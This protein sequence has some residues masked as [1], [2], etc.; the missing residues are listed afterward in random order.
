MKF[1]KSY[2]NRQRKQ[3]AAAQRRETRERFFVIVYDKT[4]D[5]VAL[6]M[7]E[8]KA[9]YSFQAAQEYAEIY[10]DSEKLGAYVQ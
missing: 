7:V 5:D 6:S 10:K 9:F 4:A 2:W 3:K 8:K 1:T